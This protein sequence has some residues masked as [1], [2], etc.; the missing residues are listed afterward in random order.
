M[1]NT[2]YYMTVNMVQNRSLLVQKGANEENGSKAKMVNTAFA[3]APY[4]HQVNLV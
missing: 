4:L 1:N 2:K 3:Y